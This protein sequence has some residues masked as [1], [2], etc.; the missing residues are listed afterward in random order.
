MFYIHNHVF[1][2]NQMHFILSTEVWINFWCLLCLYELRQILAFFPQKL[3]WHFQKT[4]KY[5]CTINTTPVNLER[6]T[7]H[8]KCHISECEC[9]SQG[10]RMGGRTCLFCKHWNGPLS[11]NIY[12]KNNL[13]NFT[14]SLPEQNLTIRWLFCP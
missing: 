1:I 14:S 7:P 10:C 11:H 5:I 2:Y 9:V 3:V 4:Q 13:R 12:L 6:L 8:Q